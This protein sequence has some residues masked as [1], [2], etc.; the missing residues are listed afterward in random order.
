MMVLKI[1][2]DIYVYDSKILNCK[3]NYIIE[4]LKVEK[5]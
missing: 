5:K 1:D 4:G 3:C 2:H